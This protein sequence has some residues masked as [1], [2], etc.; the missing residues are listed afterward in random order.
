MKIDYALAYI[1]DQMK[2]GHDL[3]FAI[4]MACVKFNISIADLTAAYNAPK[5]AKETPA[6]KTLSPGQVSD[7]ISML[8][9]VTFLAESVAHLRGLEREIL[10][11]T[12]MARALLKE[13]A[14]QD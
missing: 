8:T 10:P 4:N 12:D 13:I 6:P 7:L 1:S 14:E 11:T 9:A 3:Q 5:V 2:G